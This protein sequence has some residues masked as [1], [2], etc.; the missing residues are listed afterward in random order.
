[1]DSRQ[2]VVSWRPN[3]FA[4][5]DSVRMVDDPEV[6]GQLVERLLRQG[7]DVVV[8]TCEA[9]IADSNEQSDRRRVSTGTRPADGPDVKVVLGLRLPSLEWVGLAAC[10][11]WL[12]EKATDDEGSFGL[13]MA[14]L[15]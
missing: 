4:F 15:N 3:E 9:S 2:P 6:F 14:L 7:A 10:W 1:M 12:P 8:A 5:H 11:A 13:Q